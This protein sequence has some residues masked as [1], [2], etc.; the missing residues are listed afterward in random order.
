MRVALEAFNALKTEL[1]SLEAS[2]Y[3]SVDRFWR[4]VIP[5]EA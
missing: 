1:G 4:A 3:W 2:R 5:I